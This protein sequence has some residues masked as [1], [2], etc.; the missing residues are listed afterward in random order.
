MI[1]Y[2]VSLGVNKTSETAFNT[3]QFLHAKVH[4]DSDLSV[5]GL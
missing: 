1:P 3:L 5:T 2:H 4:I